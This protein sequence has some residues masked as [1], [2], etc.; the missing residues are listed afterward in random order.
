M[1]LAKALG[2]KAE[3]ES[4]KDGGFEVVCSAE[5]CFVPD[6]L[7]ISRPGLAYVESYEGL[8][9]LI[10]LFSTFSRGRS[11]SYRVST[12]IVR[13]VRASCAVVYCTLL[14]L[15]YRLQATTR[16]RNQ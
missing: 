14:Q 10:F 4:S 16:T 12:K 3:D 6:R 9:S 5:L 15:L 8:L 11:G 1:E 7:A 2:A 13:C